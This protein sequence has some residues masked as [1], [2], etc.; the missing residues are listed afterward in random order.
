MVLAVAGPAQ[1][2]SIWQLTHEAEGEGWANVFDGGPVEYDSAVR[3]TDQR[4]SFVAVDRT[5]SSSL[6][7]GYS[8]SGVS[9][10][11]PGEELLE[12]RFDF[13]TGYGASSSVQADRPGGEGHG[14]TASVVEFVMPVEELAWRLFFSVEESPRFD[15]SMRYLVENVTQGLTVLEVTEGEFLEERTLS[16]DAG[17]LIRM[18]FEASGAGRV[19]AGV[20]TYAAYDVRVRNEFTIPEPTSLS[21]LMLGTIAGSLRRRRT[22]GRLTARK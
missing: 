1:A 20:A 10:V 19:E 21:L 2:G 4:I 18:S 12:V 3:L 16:G 17:D 22:A 5:R 7:A 15:G 8:T 14:W 13:N 9:V 6:G 11:V